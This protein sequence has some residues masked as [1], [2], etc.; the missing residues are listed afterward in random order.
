MLLAL[1]PSHESL[2]AEFTLDG[3]HIGKLDRFVGQAQRAALH[4]GRQF[5]GVTVEVDAE[6]IVTVHAIGMRSMLL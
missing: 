1:A 3:R 6:G 4:S 5:E 2:A